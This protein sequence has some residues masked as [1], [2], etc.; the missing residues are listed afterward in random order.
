[1]IHQQSDVPKNG[2][3]FA[4]GS[5]ITIGV[6]VPVV[7]L[8]GFAF[9]GWLIMKKLRRGKKASKLSA[10]DVGMGGDGVEAIQLTEESKSKFKRGRH[11]V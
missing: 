9:G 10:A 8:L 5:K 7:I 2:G 1:M 11:W 6:V 3:G 4:L